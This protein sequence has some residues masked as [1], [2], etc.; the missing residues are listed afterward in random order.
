[1]AVHDEDHFDRR[2]VGHAELHLVRR[3]DPAGRLRLAGA[4]KRR[5]G[6]DAQSKGLS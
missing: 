1:L 2:P 3:D 4:D 6:E 5:H